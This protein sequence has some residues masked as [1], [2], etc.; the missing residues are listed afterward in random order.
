MN[1]RMVCEFLGRLPWDESA[2]ALGVAGGLAARG[3]RVKVFTDGAEDT[4]VPAGVE[5]IMRDV[6]RRRHQRQPFAF[7]RWARA[8]LDEDPSS[9]GL[10]FSRLVPSDLW[11][12][13]G[14]AE[15][16]I[17]RRVVK[18]HPLSAAMEL[19]VRPWLATSPMAE[20][21]AGSSVSAQRLDADH[22]DLV[23]ATLRRPPDLADRA[24]R[25]R[26]L[27]R[28]GSARP[29]VLLP[30]THTERAGFWAAVEGCAHAARTL[31]SQGRSLRVLLAGKHA[32]TVTRRASAIG[33]AA[34]LDPLGAIV[35]LSDA[36][37]ACDLCLVPTLGGRGRASEGTGRLLADALHHATP[38]VAWHTAPGAQ[39]LREHPASGRLVPDP[40][41]AA[42]SAPAVRFGE[43]IA[44]LLEPGARRAASEAAAALSPTLDPELLYDRIETRL[45]TIEASASPARGDRVRARGRI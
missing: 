33:L 12:P 32:A 11:L 40:D 19:V 20:R 16:A 5:M 43:Q 26:A 25:L 44:A 18:G 21:R 9:V 23:G 41:D 45:R 36:L 14:P 1:V 34:N 3:H 13:I 39:V 28:L 17:A 4:L 31:R 24:A 42:S 22:T 27:L 7:A 8:R 15:S 29:G 30:T 10:S 35:P 37:A 2:F 38:V 6:R